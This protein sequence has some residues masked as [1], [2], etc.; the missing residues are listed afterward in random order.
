[1][2]HETTKACKTCGRHSWEVA[3]G[4]CCMWCGQKPWSPPTGTMLVIWG[5]VAVV[6][7]FA[8]LVAWWVLT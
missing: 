1:M 3:N 7:G 6:A 8:G 2:K 4:A 5:M